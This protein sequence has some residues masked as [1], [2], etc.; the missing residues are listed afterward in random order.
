MILQISLK[1]ANFDENIKKLGAKSECK[2]EQDKIV[3]LLTFDLS[4]L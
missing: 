2:A 4:Y 1:K 3:K